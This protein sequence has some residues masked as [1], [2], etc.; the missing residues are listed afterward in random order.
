MF[1]ISV[2]DKVGA[3]DAL[4][5]TC[6]G[7]GV[8]FVV[9]I[10]ISFIIGLLKYVP[11]LFD[12]SRKKKVENKIPAKKEE[13]VQEF[14]TAPVSDNNNKDDSQIVAVIAAAIAAQM[15]EETGAPVTPDGLVIRSIK[16][17]TFSI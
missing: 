1:L 9:L 12:G 6:L 3:A 16:K 8:V 2:T 13:P 10:L 4:L 11:G 15:T 7:M 17:R 14:S 5:Y